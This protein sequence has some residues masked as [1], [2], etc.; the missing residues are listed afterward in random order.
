[1]ALQAP[2]VAV[3]WCSRPQWAAALQ[4]KVEAAA[5]PASRSFSKLRFSGSSVAAASAGLFSATSHAR[6]VARW[7]GAGGGRTRGQPCPP[8]IGFWPRPC[9]GAGFRRVALVALPS[10]GP[11]RCPWR[12]CGLRPLCRVGASPGCYF[13]RVA[14]SAGGAGGEA[15]VIWRVA[16]PASFFVAFCR[17]VLPSVSVAAALLLARLWP[18]GSPFSPF[19]FPLLPLGKGEKRQ[20]RLGGL[21]APHRCAADPPG[22][23]VQ[24]RPV[25]T[26]ALPL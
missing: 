12:L 6:S 19:P 21:R 20:A 7:A 23:F 11:V 18:L 5:S 25:S 9:F 2:P 8:N 26:A 13:P 1:M 10:R 3:V 24:V 4:T 14:P 15:A 17:G 22:R 16:P